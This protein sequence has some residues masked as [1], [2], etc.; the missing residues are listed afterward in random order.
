MPIA[1]VAGIIFVGAGRGA[2]PW[3]APCTF[4]DALNGVTQ[5]IPR[6][7]VGFMEAI[8]QLG[9][10]GG[11]FFNANCAHPFENP[12]GLTNLLSICLA[13]VASRSRSPTPSARWWAASATASRCSPPWCSSSAS[14]WASPPTPSTRTTRPSPRPACTRPVGNMEGKEVRFG[15]TTSALFN[16]SIDADLRPVPSTAPTDS[17]NPM[18]GF[19]AAERA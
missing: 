15:D 6:G 17:F 10:N 13:A 11:G 8:K 7:P 19:G 18:G 1:F 4:H 2:D 5:T 3:P 9:T 16:V 12:T 14:G